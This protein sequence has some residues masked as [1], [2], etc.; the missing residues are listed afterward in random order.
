MT[1]D[2][3]EYYEHINYR[4]LLKLQPENFYLHLPIQIPFLKWFFELRLQLL[5]QMN[6]SHNYFGM[7]HMLEPQA[8]WFSDWVFLNH[9][10]F[11][12][13]DKKQWKPSIAD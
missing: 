6:L 5:L 1:D 10:K 11:D 9:Y 4:E 8:Q 2:S 13:L 3:E 12:Y 7:R